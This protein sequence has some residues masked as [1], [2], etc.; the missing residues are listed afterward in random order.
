VEEAVIRKRYRCPECDGVFVYDHHPSIEADPLPDGAACP[1]CGFVADS[2]YPAAVVAP[3]IQR[4][5]VRAVDGMH[6]AM[7]EGADHRALVAQEQF[8]LSAEEANVMRDTNHRDGLRE[9]D[10][11]FAPVVN[12]VS[13][14]VDANPHALGFQG[15]AAQGVALSPQ[16][17]AGAFPNAGLRAMEQVRAA[18]QGLVSSTGHK[19]TVTSSLPALETQQPGY[20][21]RV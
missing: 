8:G 19:A 18:H 20:R 10:T 5:I 1:H 15:G 21:R 4:T 9:G 7:E 17:Q 2:E 13:R 16:V 14:M 6:R 12:D 3:A 11:S